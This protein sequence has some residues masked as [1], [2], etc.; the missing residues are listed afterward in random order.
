MVRHLRKHNR[1][2][3]R[4]TSMVERGQQLHDARSVR[5]G[6]AAFDELI[7]A[8]APD[9]PDRPACLGN[10]AAGCIALYDLAPGP[11][12]ID[13]LLH[14]QQSLADE[15]PEGDPVRDVYRRD[16]L[17]FLVRLIVAEPGPDLLGRLVPLTREAAAGRAADRSI[18]L[19]VLSVGLN[20]AAERTGRP[21][22]LAELV[23]ADRGRVA[24]SRPGD[25]S[26]GQVLIDL[27]TSLRRLALLTGRPGLLA[28]AAEAGRR[29]VRE[30]SP[31]DPDR[32]L[33]LSRCGNTLHALFTYAERSP[34]ILRESVTMGRAAVEAAPPGYAHEGTCLNNLGIALRTSF[35]EAGDLT[36]VQEAVRAGRA[37]VALSP[38]GSGVR[39]RYLANLSAASQELYKRTGR[40]PAV[41]EAVASAREAAEL[42][43]AGTP[44]RA[45][46]L[47]DLANALHL[48]SQEEDDDETA[49]EVLRES[50][51]VA[52]EAVEA[53]QPGDIAHAARLN[54]LTIVARALFERT[55]DPTALDEA[56]RAGREAVEAAAPGTTPRAV[57][58]MSLLRALAQQPPARP[59]VLEMSRHWA[60][61]TPETATPRTRA[62][63]SVLLGS[64]AMAAGE[65]ETALS[66]Y[67]KAVDLLPQLA[68]RRLLRPD[69]E[70]GLA[71]LA[72]LPADAAAAALSLGRTEEALSLLERARGLLLGESIGARRDLETLRRADPVKAGELVRLRDRLDA[73]DRGGADLYHG[74]IAADRW[75][76]DR[77]R[78]HRELAE[79][80]ERLLADIRRL[81]GLAGFL[82]PPAVVSPRLPP[83]GPVVVVNASRFRCDALLLTAGEPV[84]AIRLDCDYRDLSARAGAFQETRPDQQRLGEELAWLADRVV[85]PVLAAL[86]LLAPSPRPA[87]D[88]PRIWWCPVG[89]ASFLPL[90]AAA[91]D[92]VV[93]SY[94]A[95]VGALQPRD[96]PARRSGAGFLVVQMDRTPGARDLP[97]AR[98]EAQHLAELVP[99]R[100]LLAGAEATRD[101]VL[102]ALPGQRIVHFACHA[103]TDERSPAL[104]RLLLHDHRSAPL[105]AIELSA[106]DTAIELGFLSACET[107]RS[108]EA[109]ADEV[110]HIATA[111][112]LAGCRH[113]VGT[114]WPVADSAAGRIA[115]DFYTAL[116]PSFDTG[117]T[118]RALHR[119]VHAL[120]ADAPDQP[121]R[122]A[123][124]VHLES[125]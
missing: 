42:S 40:R 76:G 100:T 103:V 60:E 96:T 19:E 38:P 64:T 120:R 1:A 18:Q 15:L 28:E 56:V 112:Q 84:R 74:D 23:E 58:Q 68:P 86:G 77:T 116:A 3:A 81:P 121:S 48:L 57:S 102:A 88:A 124:H 114:L 110:M 85:E 7:E 66:A 123:A 26:H 30:G 5:D 36:E 16:L 37:A 119:A 39:A 6:L 65:H 87:A 107:A 117:G 47:T 50:V 125:A 69:R 67:G 106:V 93:S 54:N 91:L 63:V 78:E 31:D 59:V 35:E 113:V 61:L 45:G 101:A 109:L 111:V 98:A 97:A 52:R 82:R 4:A 72:G 115:A 2:A 27:S 24:A 90:H 122:W 89:I 118:A 70:H 34:A 49:L 92:H 43:P 22:L 12:V 75:P 46:R 99:G 80:W 44:E 71:E 11:G 53:G 20:A 21:D 32:A 14:A 105:T 25:A 83:D 9:H 95:T 41:G 51:R 108:S 62:V 13:R 55:G 104:N 94:T 29:A 73:S 33:L 10:R 17:V 8:M 79:R